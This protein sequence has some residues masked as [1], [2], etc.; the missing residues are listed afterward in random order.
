MDIEEAQPRIAHLVRER[1]TDRVDCLLIRGEHGAGKSTLLDHIARE[2]AEHCVSIAVPWGTCQ[3]QAALLVAGLRQLRSVVAD[4]SSGRE[5]DHH[6]TS[7]ESAE[8]SAAWLTGE[9]D[10]LTTRQAASG[11]PFWLLVDDVD[12]LHPELLHA[13]RHLIT[14]TAHS[15]GGV[16]CTATWDVPELDQYSQLVLDPLSTSAVAGR[17]EA[18]SGRRPPRSVAQRL[19]HWSNA[20]VALLD[21]LIEEA[22]PDALAGMRLLVPG[23]PTRAAGTHAERALAHADPATTALLATL[24]STI[25]IDTSAFSKLALDFGLDPEQFWIDGWVR[26]SGTTVVLEDGALARYLQYT[27]GSRGTREASQKVLTV[28]ADILSDDDAL[29]LHARATRGKESVATSLAER[30]VLAALR[31]E[32]D[33]AAQ[34]TAATHRHITRGGIAGISATHAIVALLDGRLLDAI[35]LSDSESRRRAADR[36]RLQLACVH[37]LAQALTSGDI[38]IGGILHELRENSS[39]KCEMTEGLVR[40]VVLT[41]LTLGHASAGRS[42]VHA[43]STAL[44]SADTTTPVWTYL[45]SRL[46]EGVRATNLRSLVSKLRLPNAYIDPLIISEVTQH[47]SAAK[48]LQRI[49]GCLHAAQPALTRAAL[50]VQRARIELR[51]GDHHAAEATLRALEDVLPLEWYATAERLT[52]ALQ[53]RTDSSRDL[54]PTEHQVLQQQ[55]LDSPTIPM[56]RLAL[57]LGTWHLG[58]DEPG[59]GESLIAKAVSSLSVPGVEVTIC[60]D[61]DLELTLPVLHLAACIRRGHLEEAIAYVRDTLVP[62]A[63]SSTH[64]EVA[65]HWATDLVGRLKGPGRIGAIT[66]PTVSPWANTVT[67]RAWDEARRTFE[68]ISPVAPMTQT[69][70]PRLTSRELEVARRAAS[71]MRNKEIAAEV[72][73]SVRSVEATMTGLFRKTGTTSRVALAALLHATGQT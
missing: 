29:L 13:L 71:G 64:S 18:A 70:L 37:S 7:D 4:H 72:Y 14:R 46:A 65:A 27:G 9:L 6:S 49:H 68:G 55:R 25:E 48:A 30:A 33:R 11:V 63:G 16:I 1:L 38:E 31:G 8:F 2:R 73:L 39:V 20:R 51:H 62:R 34:L 69:P 44:G 24:A 53:L 52:I 61:A 42:L 12:V 58:R 36:D 35:D 60:N 5:P 10:R 57:A 50:L 15:P 66:T 23:N 43:F 19:R 67:A 3:E 32:S 59:R 22:D 54:E 17:V 21:E 47:E 41:S 26:S 56:A 40:S 45:R 28:A